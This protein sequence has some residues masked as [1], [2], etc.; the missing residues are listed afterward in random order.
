M[1]KVYIIRKVNYHVNRKHNEVIED[2]DRMMG[3]LETLD[4]ESRDVAFKN[5]FDATEMIKE[6]ASRIEF[7]YICKRVEEDTLSDDDWVTSFTLSDKT[8]TMSRTYETKDFDLTLT[9]TIKETGIIVF[10][11]D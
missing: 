3:I 2:Y 8:A 6:I 4:D 10:D 9:F 7:W 5:F 11:E 1:K